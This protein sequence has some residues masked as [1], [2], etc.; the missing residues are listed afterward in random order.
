MKILVTGA[1]GQLGRCLVDQGL[2]K[3]MDI[4]AC[5]I[6]DLDI[7]NL[8]AMRHKL[9]GSAPDFVINAAAYTAV[10][11]AESEPEKAFAVN[12]QGALNVAVACAQYDI[13][14]L[15]ISTDYVFS[16]DASTAYKTSDAVAPNSVY[17]ASKLAGEYAVLNHC[18]KSLIVR[19]AWLFSEY[20]DNFVK[21]MLGLA[22]SRDL[23]ALVSDQVGNPTY[24]GDIARALLDICKSGKEQWGV[25]HYAGATAMSW[26]QFAKA[27]FAKAQSMG[28]VKNN[29]E[30]E[31]I[32]TAEYPTAA[33]RP[34]YSVL[35]TEKTERVFGIKPCTLE[36]SLARMLHAFSGR[37]A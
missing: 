26:S 15:H 29:I 5:D 6:A 36:D 18:E 31:S 3:G 16:G 19:T 33:A 35:A 10:D 34:A 1:K 17:G 25:Y 37:S 27:V 20:G 8:E 22:E 14:L 2:S 28:L 32:T 4:D 21:T 24:A 23:L 12:E 30:V 11:R 7:T 13:P 9:R